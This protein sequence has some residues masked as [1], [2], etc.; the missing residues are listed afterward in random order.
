MRSP[1]SNP[2]GL[3]SCVNRDGPLAR[4]GSQSSYEYC[5]VISLLKFSPSPS[6][7]WDPPTSSPFEWPYPIPSPI[8]FCP[9]PQHIQNNKIKGST[10]VH[11]VPSCFLVSITFH[12]ISF[13]ALISICKNAVHL[14]VYCHRLTGIGLIS[15]YT[16]VNNQRLHFLF[17]F[18]REVGNSTKR[19]KI[20]ESSVTFIQRVTHVLRGHTISGCARTPG[21]EAFL[22]KLSFF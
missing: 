14:F 11:W 3:C 9:S 18:Y 2:P 7:G 13:R 22:T 10:L 20:S 15:A 19:S 16:A 1:L 4:P 5:P 6:S 8:Y 17:V 21:S 12:L